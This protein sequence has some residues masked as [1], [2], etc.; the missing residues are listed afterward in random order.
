MGYRDA[1]QC[2]LWFPPYKVPLD[3]GQECLVPVLVM[4]CAY[5]R[6]TVCV[7]IPTRTTADLLQGMWEGVQ[8]F[9][10][11]PRRFIW[12]NESGIGRGNHLAAGVSGFMGVL[13]ATVKQLPP[14][15]PGI[16]RDYRAV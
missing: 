4:A 15:R 16:Q 3:D 5:S 8:R 1:I 6:Y 13:G 7:V 2:D 10:G 9:G 12:D 11:V 14:Q